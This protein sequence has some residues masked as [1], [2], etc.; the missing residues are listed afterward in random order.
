MT[1]K[2]FIGPITIF[3]LLASSLACNQPKVGAFVPNHPWMIYESNSQGVCYADIDN[4]DILYIIFALEEGNAIR[5]DLCKK[6]TTP[7]KFKTK[8]GEPGKTVIYHP[9]NVYE[10]KSLSLKFKGTMETRK[11][12]QW[13]GWPG[14]EYQGT[15]SVVYYTGTWFVLDKRGIGDIELFHL[16]VANVEDDVGFGSFDVSPDGKWLVA[17]MPIMPFKNYQFRYHIFNRED[18]ITEKAR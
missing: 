1:L 4:P 18:I 3:L 12:K 9:E 14:K 2:A 7:C 13:F 17:Q 11:I 15:R 5:I 8:H 6:T 10:E 16:D